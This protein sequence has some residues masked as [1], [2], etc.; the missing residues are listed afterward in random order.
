MS[1][2]LFN[3]EATRRMEKEAADRRIWREDRNSAHETLF[4]KRQQKLMDLSSLDQSTTRMKIILDRKGDSAEQLQ[5]LTE[6]ISDFTSFIKRA[7]EKEVNTTTLRRKLSSL[8]LRAYSLYKEM[9]KHDRAHEFNER[10]LKKLL[11][12]YDDLRK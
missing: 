6:L 1:Y 9:Q 4:L 3:P 2:S 8:Q 7:E 11:R 12:D 5:A 10:D